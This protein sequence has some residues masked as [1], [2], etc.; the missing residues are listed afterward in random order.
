MKNDP[1]KCAAQ[2]LK[3]N[4]RFLKEKDNKVIKP[5]KEMTPRSQRAERKKWAINAKNYRKK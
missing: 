3:E 1:A 4:A 5:I 2:K